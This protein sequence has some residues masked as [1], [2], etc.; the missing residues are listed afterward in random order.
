M[1]T[2]DYLKSE[3]CPHCKRDNGDLHIGKSSAGW[4]FGLRIYPVGDCGQVLTFDASLG[5]ISSLADWLPLFERF[6]IVD[7][8]GQPVTAEQ[9]VACIT[10]RTHPLGLQHREQTSWSKPVR[11]DGTY[12][13]LSWEFS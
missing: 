2:N 1:G 5:A 9:M 7:E 12:D 11:G 6:R 13:L 4:A 8:Y 10:K 3:P